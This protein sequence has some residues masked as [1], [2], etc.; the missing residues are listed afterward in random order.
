MGVW[1]GP[2]AMRNPKLQAK[3]LAAM[4]DMIGKGLLNPRVT[5]SYALEEFS[6][7]RKLRPKILSISS[8]C[9]AR[10]S[11]HG[12]SPICLSPALK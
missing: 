8:R 6:E 1:W 5:G 10:F 4:D 9:G 7:W 2:W 11:G 3:N 12:S